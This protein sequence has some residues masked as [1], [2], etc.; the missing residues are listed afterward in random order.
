MASAI[1]SISLHNTGAILIAA[2]L[3]WIALVSFLALVADYLLRLVGRGRAPGGDRHP[4]GFESLT[5]TAAAGVLG[6]R[7]AVLDVRWAALTLT[8]VA[9][10]SWLVLSYAV[11][12][13][14]LVRT[15]A[16]SGLEGVDGTWF[17]WV[18]GTQVVA[19]AAGSYA[20]AYS[21]PVFASIAAVAWS[22][23]V[24][25]FLLIASV[26]FARLLLT[27]LPPDAEAAPYWV[28][29]GSASIIVL[30]GAELM[31]LRSEQ[32]LLEQPAIST[33]S[34]VMWSFST[35]LIPLIVALSLWQ[36]IRPGGRTGFRPA[37]WSMVFPI[38]MYGEASRQVGK[39]RGTTWLEDIGLYEAWL[40]FAVWLF[41]FASML[42][43]SLARAVSRGRADLP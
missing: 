27:P 36:R 42:V 21:S 9:G 39:I 24:L 29:M 19:V 34:M 11:I 31:N 20:V 32:T 23:G 33:I 2:I 25:Q 30:A 38:G 5:F 35:W 17:L 6:A 41:V 40:A 16:R 7:F 14:K 28:F 43:W 3:F 37:M 8:V 4:A 15:S 18:V 26:A 13:D 22:I 12:I 1:V 10:V